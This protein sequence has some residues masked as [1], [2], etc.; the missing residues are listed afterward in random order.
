MI[1]DL[2]QPSAIWL[3]FLNT[4]NPQNGVGTPGLSTK[5]QEKGSQIISVLT[6]WSSLIFIQIYF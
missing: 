5:G 2:F 4:E 6:T 3:I 1:Y